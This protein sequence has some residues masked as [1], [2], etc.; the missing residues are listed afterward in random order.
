MK[1]IQTSRI[2]KKKIVFLIIGSALLSACNHGSSPNTNNSVTNKQELAD[3]NYNSKKIRISNN[4]GSTIDHISIATESGG[5]I[6]KSMSGL[7]CNSG[8]SCYVDIHNSKLN[9]KML[10]NFYNNKNQLISISSLYENSQNLEYSN[11]YTSNIIF[12]AHL[13]TNIAK[14]TKT[15]KPQLLLQLN[16][17]F[18]HQDPNASVFNDLGA[19]Y[20]QQLAN[21]SIHNENDFYQLI[22]KNIHNH[23]HINGNLLVKANKS[24]LSAPVLGCNNELGNKIFDTILPFAK[25]TPLGESF[26][27]VTMLGQALFNWAC[28]SPSGP[29]YTAQL[30]QINEKLADIQASISDL[31]GDM[32]EL[33]DLVQEQEF[34]KEQVVYGNLLSKED[35]YNSIYLNYMAE[36]NNGRSA[37]S[38][39]KSLYSYAVANGGVDNL[40]KQSLPLFATDNGVL[41]GL[42]NQYSNLQN[43]YNNIPYIS[44][45]I[46]EQCSN[47]DI[48]SG[49]IIAK[50]NYCNTFTIQLGMQLAATIH[51]SRLRMS[52]A[53]AT[54]LTSKNTGNYSN[55]F[56]GSTGVTWSQAAKLVES[57]FDKNMESINT[58]Y[59]NTL[60]TP[61]DGLPTDLLN[62]LNESG[63]P[64]SCDPATAST[65]GVTGLLEWHANDNGKLAT[66]DRYIITKCNRI[67]E[68]PVRTVP[69]TSRYYYNVDGDKVIS[70]LGTLVGNNAL[71]DKGVIKRASYGDDKNGV[72]KST[73][74][75]D[76]LQYKVIFSAQPYLI[77]DKPF[78]VFNEYGAVYSVN[79]VRGFAGYRSDPNTINSLWKDTTTGQSPT[80]IN[81][82]KGGD[83]IAPPV[84][85]DFY[86]IMRANGH[87][88]DFY[89]WFANN[90]YY[91]GGNELASETIVPMSYPFEV[92]DSKTNKKTT[93]WF[94]WGFLTK[95]TTSFV[96]GYRRIDVY[97]SVVCT[98]KHN[99]T[100][101]SDNDDVANKDVSIITFTLQDGTQRGVRFIWKDISASKGGSFYVRGSW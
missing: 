40:D 42:T 82:H 92:I 3:K 86:G 18:N 60:I 24:L 80:I 63:N 6:F 55:P 49:D 78:S 50:R 91:R 11:I 72:F 38:S 29:D 31:A 43:I 70:V 21:G 100:S 22:A 10:I 1:F 73:I 96:D 69:I 35:I 28:P 32:Q 2:S 54:I 7:N 33:T 97:S 65:T 53:I 52:D 76:V 13:F 66:N 17:L 9:R 58:F 83:N 15:D 4:T 95:T 44:S 51:Q 64:L 36:V 12:G 39:Y 74:H 88:L 26:E 93:Q 77:N 81:W 85:D 16:K 67:L 14:F 57:D 87:D 61:T 27:G 99:C 101:G 56:K 90:W 47:I 59:K 71:T 20:A 62:K 89:Y 94:T 5:N 46:N 19:Y 23:K 34:G 75:L 98:T 30:D 45:L 68:G 37:E 84:I 48:I 79:G 41:N 8:N 25:L